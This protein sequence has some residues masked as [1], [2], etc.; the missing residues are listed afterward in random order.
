MTRG[1]PD[2]GG[3]CMLFKQRTLGPRGFHGTSNNAIETICS[4]RPT[5][6][7][8]TY[9]NFHRIKS[10]RTII[11]G[12]KIQTHQNFKCHTIFAKNK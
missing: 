9:R 3:Y 2:T 5:I 4:F 6:T 11:D 7:K 1:F 10:E 8:N 12:Q